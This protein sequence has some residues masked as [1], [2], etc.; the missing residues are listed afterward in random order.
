MRITPLLSVLAVA[1]AIVL[2]P[3]RAPADTNPSEPGRFVGRL[4]G[5]LVWAMAG[6]DAALRVHAAN[7]LILDAVDLTDL[8]RSSAGPLW[9]TGS[10][11]DQAETQRLIL[12]A[13]AQRTAAGADVLSTTT[14]TV[15]GELAEAEGVTIVHTEARWAGYVPV[16]IDWRIDWRVVA[17][18]AGR[19]W[20]EDVVIEGLSVRALLRLAAARLVGPEASLAALNQAIGDLAGPAPASGP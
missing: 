1:A 17:G 16:R 7:A 15:L 13:L 12:G 10:A 11:A 20:I 5:Q 18:G 6:S 19:H 4:F 2:G 9:A 8:A 3:A 14:L